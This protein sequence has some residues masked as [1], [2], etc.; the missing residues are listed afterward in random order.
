M[1]SH[2]GM[3][4]ALQTGLGVYFLLVMVMNLGFAAHYHFAAR[5]RLQMLIWSGVSVAYFVVALAYLGHAGPALPH[6]LESFV[7]WVLGPT[8]YFVMAVIGLTAF[9]YFRK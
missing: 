2:E 5:N 8:T 4:T 9:L 6:G 3:S 1:H 7:N